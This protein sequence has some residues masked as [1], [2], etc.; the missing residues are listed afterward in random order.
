M[1]IASKAQITKW[2]YSLCVCMKKEVLI[3]HPVSQKR[4]DFQGNTLIPTAG[5]Q[6]LKWHPDKH[7]QPGMRPQKSSAGPVVGSRA[8]KHIQ[9]C[10]LCGETV[11]YPLPSLQQLPPAL[12]VCALMCRSTS[13]GCT[14]CSPPALRCLQPVPFTVATSHANKRFSTHEERRSSKHG[15]DALPA[16]CLLLVF[17]LLNTRVADLPLMR[18]ENLTAHLLL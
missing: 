16:T 5:Q 7:L 18:E 4:A 14:V 1:V 12:E 13:Y 11:L 3:L 2:N 15:S 8:Q 9:R 17:L 6:A 10:A